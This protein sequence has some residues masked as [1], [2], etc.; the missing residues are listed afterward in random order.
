MLRD[1]NTIMRTFVSDARK[2]LV[3][4]DEDGV[5]VEIRDSLS[6]KICDLI[7]FAIMMSQ[8]AVSPQI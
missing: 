1:G 2:K 6:L 5:T 7:R 3:S 8:L 4:S